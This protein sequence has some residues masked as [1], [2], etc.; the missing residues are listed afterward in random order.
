[1][2]RHASRITL[3]I[4]RVRLERLQDI[5]EEDARAEGIDDGWLVREKFPTAQ[6]AYQ[7]LWDSINAKKYPWS[8]NP[9][10]WVIEFRRI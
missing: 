8:A 4:V 2:L 10:V 9:W 1:M 7:Y 3:E 6:V 5:S